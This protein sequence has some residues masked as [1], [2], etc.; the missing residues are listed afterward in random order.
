MLTMTYLQLKNVTKLSEPKW[1][2]FEQLQI[3]LSK[4]KN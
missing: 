1:E 4:L 3:W 2:L